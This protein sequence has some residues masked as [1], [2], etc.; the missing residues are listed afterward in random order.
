MPKG[1]RYSGSRL[2]LARRVLHTIHQSD[3]VPAKISPRTAP[4]RLRTFS[5]CGH[6]DID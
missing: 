3:P 6:G 5:C 4:C 2:P 1:N